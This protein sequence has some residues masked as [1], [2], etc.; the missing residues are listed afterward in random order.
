MIFEVYGDVAL[1]R[2]QAAL[3]ERRDCDDN[4]NGPSGGVAVHA[5]DDSCVLFSRQVVRAVDLVGTGVIKPYD[6]EAQWRKRL[7]QLV[8]P[9]ASNDF[10]NA[11]PEAFV[12]R[13]LFCRPW[14]ESG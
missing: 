8:A 11:P 5:S 2:V 12:F 3:L 6:C 14:R 9:G 10:S 1:E 13:I 7:G 4:L